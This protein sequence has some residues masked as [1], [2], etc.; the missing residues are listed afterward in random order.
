MSRLHLS[1]KQNSMIETMAREV[2]NC[3]GGSYGT[4]CAAMRDAY[5]CGLLNITYTELQRRQE[6]E[7]AKFLEP[8]I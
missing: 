6:D 7:R 5:L 3:A 8:A 1:H 4:V 2:V